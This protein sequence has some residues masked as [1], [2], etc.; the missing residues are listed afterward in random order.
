MT[1]DKDFYSVKEFA[2]KLGVSYWTILRAI[3][4]GRINAIQPGSSYRIP[5]SE[6]NRMGTVSLAKIVEAM[7]EKRMNKVDL[8]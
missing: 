1:Q 4:N 2:D 3:K 8:K 7:V 5:H 6:F